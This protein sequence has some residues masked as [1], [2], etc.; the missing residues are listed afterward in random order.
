MDQ[1]VSCHARSEVAWT[2]NKASVKP[3]SRAIALIHRKLR[4]VKRVQ[5]GTFIASPCG[6]EMRTDAWMLQT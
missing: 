6:R 3:I 2:K 1:A 4:V 5:I